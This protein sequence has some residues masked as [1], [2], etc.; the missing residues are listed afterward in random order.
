MAWEKKHTCGLTWSRT[1][2]ALGDETPPDY[3]IVGCATGGDLR[4]AL[5]TGGRT[6]EHPACRRTRHGRQGD[7]RRTRL[8]A[9]T[10]SLGLCAGCLPARCGLSDGNGDRAA[11]LLDAATLKRVK[12]LSSCSSQTG[13]PSGRARVYS[14]RLPRHRDEKDSRRTQVRG[15][16]SGPDADSLL[17]GRQIVGDVIWGVTAA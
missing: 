1:R 8:G 5:A 9:Y 6:G 4:M 13:R 12:K 2:L 7:Q 3:L 14:L 10:A 15:S 16:C 17:I 11:G